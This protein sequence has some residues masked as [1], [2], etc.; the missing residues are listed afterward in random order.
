MKALDA[1]IGVLR[2]IGADV[3]AWGILV[4]FWTSGLFLGVA[5]GMRIGGIS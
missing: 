5:I 3:P 4:W 2:R 1:F